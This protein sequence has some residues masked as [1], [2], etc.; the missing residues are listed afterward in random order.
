MLPED[1]GGWELPVALGSAGALALSTAIARRIAVHPHEENAFRLVNELPS[2]LFPPVYGVMQ[3]GSL[4]AVFVVAAVVQRTVG[5]K[6]GVSVFTAGFL[7]WLGSKGIKRWVQRGRPSAHLEDVRMR[8]PEDRGLGFPSG[9]SA[10]A[11]G[12]ATTLT[13]CL[14][15]PVSAAVWALA[16][17]VALS[18]LYVGAHLPLDI[19]GGAAL[20]G[21]LGASVR[22]AARSA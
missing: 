19:V 16:P 8:G 15:E 21:L 14:P 3:A 1:A 4:A 2:A 11:F 12:M 9:H 6:A 13:G 17:V 7:G 18:R 22:I 5:T 10:V 20:G